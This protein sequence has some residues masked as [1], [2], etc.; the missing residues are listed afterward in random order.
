MPH[1]NFDLLHF[2]LMNHL[3]TS[4]TLSTTPSNRVWLMRLTPLVMSY[5]RDLQL[6]M[7]NQLWQQLLNF[8]IPMQLLF[9]KEKLFWQVNCK[10]SIN[11]NYVYLQL[12]HSNYFTRFSLTRVEGIRKFSC[13]NNLCV[14]YSY[15][16]IFMGLWYPR[17][18]FN[19][20]IFLQEH[21]LPL[22][23]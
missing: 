4:L 5:C 13:E 12:F 8:R 3:D 23:Y 21:L 6:Y 17:K 11:N 16:L 7:S 20:N 18:Y 9:W 15:Q 19:T 14:K 1:L 10:L 2:L 22:Y